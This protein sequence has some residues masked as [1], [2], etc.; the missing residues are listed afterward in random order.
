MT[1]GPGGPGRAAWEPGTGPEERMTDL[2]ALMW[3][4]GQHDPR[5]V[6]T[7]SML[8]L[9]DRPLDRGVLLDRLD[10]L[11]RRVP[12]L[13][14]RVAPSALPAVPPRWEPDPDFSLGRHVQVATWRRSL[15]E[16]EGEAEGAAGGV[17]AHPDLLSVAQDVVSC[18]FVAGRAPWRAVLVPGETDALVLH[19]HHSYTDGLGGLLLLAEL[20]DLMA[21]GDERATDPSGPG[22]CSVLDA[23]SGDLHAAF[24]RSAG[25]ARSVVPWSVRSIRAASADPAALLGAA[26]A[27]ARSARSALV[28]AAGPPSPVLGGRS[29]ATV[30]ATLDVPLDSLR[31]VGGRLGATVNDVYL[32]TL[33]EGLARYH[34]KFAARPP[35][36]RLAVPMSA[37]LDGRDE[38]VMRNHLQAAL[39]RGPLGPLDFDERTRL[40]HQMVALARRQP[41]LDLMDV[42]AGIGMRAPGA[43]RLMAAALRSLDVVASNVS[44][45]SSALHLGGARARAM[46]PFG[47]RSGSAVNATLLS[48]AGTAH[49]GLNIDPE[50]VAD[51]AAM[52]DCVGAVVQ[53]HLR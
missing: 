37:R 33:L 36:L 28:A 44:G 43:V 21:S 25:L 42:T 16:A 1:G 18:P 51:P 15:R 24:Q 30:L 6:S 27:A 46:V 53:E 41:W 31:N 9:F 17:C 20:F 47:P 39:L 22:G 23:F 32:A 48:Y 52:L 8:V 19:L 40:V 2:E 26:S 29:A 11:S 35:S 49:I 12:R 13:R 10:Q 34:E 7:M 3:R 4:L 50:A 45:P 5:L 14:C 38:M